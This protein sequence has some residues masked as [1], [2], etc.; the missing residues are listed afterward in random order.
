MANLLISNLCA[1][2]VTKTNPDH[3]ELG[4]LFGKSIRH[5]AWS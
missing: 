1:F 3:S 4:S 5:R 2:R